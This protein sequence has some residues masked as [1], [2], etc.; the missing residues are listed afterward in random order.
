MYVASQDKCPTNAEAV[1]LRSQITVVDAHYIRIVPPKYHPPKGVIFRARIG[2]GDDERFPA[3]GIRGGPHT[4]L[5]SMNRGRTLSSFNCDQSINQHCAVDR[6][7]RST[8]G[9]MVDTELPA[10]T[11]PSAELQCF[12]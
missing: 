12:K 9:C 8:S 10:P 3:H 6:R 1:F 11:G 4:F 2:K 5:R 7:T